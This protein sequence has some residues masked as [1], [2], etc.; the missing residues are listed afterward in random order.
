MLTINHWEDYRDD[1]LAT[2]FTVATGPSLSSPRNLNENCVYESGLTSSD[3]PR[4][5]GQER[6][7][8]SCECLN[9]T[10]LGKSKMPQC[11][12]LLGGSWYTPYGEIKSDIAVLW[13]VKAQDLVRFCTV[14]PV[15]WSFLNE[16]GAADLCICVLVTTYRRKVTCGLRRES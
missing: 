15:P 9:G 2:P 4:T 5:L 12:R 10:T 14:D 3:T 11:L 13:D 1:T 16:H 7:W 8:L 6:N